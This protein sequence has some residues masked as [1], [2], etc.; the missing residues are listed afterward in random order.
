MERWREGFHQISK[1]YQQDVFLWCIPERLK[2][3]DVIGQK[4]HNTCN[5]QLASKILKKNLIIYVVWVS[6]LCLIQC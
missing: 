5:S 1:I 4:S 3:L 2:L 6:A